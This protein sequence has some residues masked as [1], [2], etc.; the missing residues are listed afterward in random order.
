MH[1]NEETYQ[2]VVDQLSYGID[3]AK[4]I[5]VNLA[6]FEP[7]LFLDIMI[8]NGKPTRYCVFKEDTD[9]VR[10]VLNLAK[11]EFIRNGHGSGYNTNKIELIRAH[12][13]L[14]RASL[15]E[16]KDWVESIPE[17]RKYF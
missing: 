17:Y 3:N 11:A 12:R 4:N 5:L 13:T 15:N 14:T 10:H 2:Q 7:E 9:L 1:I 8:N 16:S 6:T